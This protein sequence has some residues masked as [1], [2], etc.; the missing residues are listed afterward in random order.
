V[1]DTLRDVLTEFGYDAETAAD[2]ASGLARFEDGVW[3]SS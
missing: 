3:M 2:G 1:R